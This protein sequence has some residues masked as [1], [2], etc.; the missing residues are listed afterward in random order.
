[1]TDDTHHREY[2]DAVAEARNSL[3]RSGGGT[4]AF[5]RRD[6]TLDRVEW[7]TEDGRIL[8]AGGPVVEEM[9]RQGPP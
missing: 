7:I 2:R 5:W 8:E 1:M 3:M 6:G 4:L 9:R